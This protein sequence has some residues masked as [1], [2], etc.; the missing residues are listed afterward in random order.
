VEVAL[1]GNKKVVGFCARWAPRI[2]F[3]HEIVPYVINDVR[4][5]HVLAT[6]QTLVVLDFHL[7]D[8]D[9]DSVWPYF[10]RLVFMPYVISLVISLVVE[11][12]GHIRDTTGGERGVP[13]TIP[14]PQVSELLSTIEVQQLEVDVEGLLTPLIH[15]HVDPCLSDVVIERTPELVV[16]PSHR[17]LCHWVALPVGIR[18]D[19]INVPLAHLVEHG[20]ILSVFATNVNDLDRGTCRV[21]LENFS[22]YFIETFVL[23]GI[24]KSSDVRVPSGRESGDFLLAAGNLEA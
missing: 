13:E 18:I 6:V 19:T 4:D 14:S 5:L 16:L 11:A 17:R 2:V 12:N 22:H 7:V 1:N 20:Y 3:G 8:L 9:C 24:V 10:A 23:Q 21:R 15:C